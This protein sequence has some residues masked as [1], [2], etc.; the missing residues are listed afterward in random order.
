MPRRLL[1]PHAHNPFHRHTHSGCRTFLKAR[2]AKAASGVPRTVPS[3]PHRTCRRIGRGLRD[4][5]P[6]RFRSRLDEERDRGPSRP[7]AP[8]PGV[9]RGDRILHARGDP[10]LPPSVD[11]ALLL[12]SDQ[13]HVTTEL[14][15]KIIAS[16]TSTGKPIVACE[17]GGT[18][19]VPALF[20]RAF[21]DRLLQLRGDSGARGILQQNSDAVFRL[22]FPEGNIDIDTI[23]DYQNL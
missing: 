3:S 21:F 12:V 23:T 6:P 11:A 17:Y 16:R 8:Q 13:P 20:S 5:R 14:L 10:P 2:Y 7:Y 1:R 18:V 9:G 19:G 15:E 22:P 4:D